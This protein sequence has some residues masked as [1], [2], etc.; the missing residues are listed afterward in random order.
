MPMP[1]PTPEPPGVPGPLKSR[2]DPPFLNRNNPHLLIRELSALHLETPDGLVDDEVVLNW[3]I[4]VARE[5]ADGL[6][7]EG[8][9]WTLGSRASMW[10]MVPVPFVSYCLRDCLQNY[11]CSASYGWYLA[12][13]HT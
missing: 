8:G 5:G 11:W 9:T 4:P 1:T 3:F 12:L 6:G 13:P 7:G 10:E 2:S